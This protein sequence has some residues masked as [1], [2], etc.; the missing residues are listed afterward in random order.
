MAK[1]LLVDDSKFQRKSMSK[2]LT[3]LGHKVSEA[4]NGEMGLKMVDTVQ[5]DLIIT[6]LLMPVLDGIGLLRGLKKKGCPIP[7][8]VVSADIQVST[9]QECLQIGAKAFLTKPINSA[10]MEATLNQ[11]VTPGRKEKTIC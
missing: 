4:E 7:A 5:P 11:F 6:D 8:I 2:L 10:D 3:D 1:I 9:R